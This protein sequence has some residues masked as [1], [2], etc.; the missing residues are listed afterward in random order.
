[1]HRCIIYAYINVSSENVV[2]KLKYVYD[3]LSKYVER[4]DFSQVKTLI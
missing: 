1:M 4:N 2:I 3:K